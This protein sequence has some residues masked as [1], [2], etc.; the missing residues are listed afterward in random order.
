MRSEL[1]GDRG[2]KQ[3]RIRNVGHM[4][5]KGRRRN[6][7]HTTQVYV[8]N[9]NSQS[10]IKIEVKHR[11]PHMAYRTCMDLRVH[12]KNCKDTSASIMHS[13]IQ[14]AIRCRGMPKMEPPGGHARGAKAC[15]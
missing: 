10:A 6:K 1:D 9:G 5:E 4:C 7:K 12:H 11:F 8:S 13:V 2:E 3:Q 15:K 14:K